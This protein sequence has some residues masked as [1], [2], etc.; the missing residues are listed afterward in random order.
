VK[1][2]QT[3]LPER[4]G[5]GSG[6]FVT[7]MKLVQGNSHKGEDWGLKESVTTGLSNEAQGR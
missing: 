3:K 6:L 7:S 4:T 5:Q 1:I 2:G